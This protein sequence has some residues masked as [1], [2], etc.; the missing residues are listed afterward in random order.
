VKGQ[1]F[2]RPQ[3][4]YR[5]LA[6]IID[7]SLTPSG[8]D[9]FGRIIDGYVTL[10]D[11]VRS[12]SRPQVSEETY[13]NYKRERYDDDHC[14]SHDG[15]CFLLLSYEE[16]EVF[17]APNGPFCS[18]ATLHGLILR[19]IPDRPK[20]YKMVGT[21]QYL[22]EIGLSDEERTIYPEF[23]NFDVENFGQEVVTII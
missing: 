4:I 22:L 14:I 10:A 3:H 13:W 16:K 19:L 8:C 11:H 23:T 17:M 6:T 21:F 15:E 2:F 20:T 1:V 18:P 5:P 12:R 7:A 9:E